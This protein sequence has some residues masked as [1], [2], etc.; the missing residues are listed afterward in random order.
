VLYQL[1]CPGPGSHAITLPLF[2]LLLLEQVWTFE[3]RLLICLRELSPSG[4]SS[5]GR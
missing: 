1:D 3:G 2:A 4:S 5:R